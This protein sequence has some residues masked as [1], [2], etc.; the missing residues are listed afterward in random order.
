[1]GGGAGR[2]TRKLGMEAGMDRIGSGVSR[3]IE[4]RTMSGDRKERRVVSA[5]NAPNPPCLSY[6]LRSTYALSPIGDDFP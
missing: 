3:A 5:H 6:F 1:M 4:R 2:E